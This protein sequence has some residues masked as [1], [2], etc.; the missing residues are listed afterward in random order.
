MITKCDEK[1]AKWTNDG[2]WFMIM[3]IQKF[4]KEIIPQ[5]FNST[6][7]I[8]FVRQLN[9]YGFKE[10]QDKHIR[11]SDYE[12]N[13]AFVTFM[14]ENFKC[15]RP[16]LLD[17][18]Q[19]R[20]IER[21][22]KIQSI[23]EELET[24]VTKLNDNIDSL[25]TKLVGKVKDLRPRLIILERL[26]F[27]EGYEMP[28]PL[29]ASIPK[30]SENMANVQPSK[31]MNS[32]DETT[33]TS[34]NYSRKELNSRLMSITKCAVALKEPNTERRLSNIFRETP[35]TKNYPDY[36]EVIDHPISIND[37]NRKCR[38]CNYSSVNDFIND[39]KLMFAN[40]K[41]YNGENSYIS[42]NASILAD[43]LQ[44]LLDKNN[45]PFFPFCPFTFLS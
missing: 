8:S 3:N 37:I 44:Q 35:C 12:E 21:A 33:Y 22:G 16:D 14:N 2:N 19:C 10:V 11:S 43:A 9:N 13:K 6:K 5:Y 31:M 45:I 23:L 36:Y 39:W 18:I 34:S 28:E 27:K 24:R 26:M 30:T 42:V 41:E 32:T 15:D 38:A 1:I 25:N 20:T 7:Y 40:A 29:T 17:N 4:E